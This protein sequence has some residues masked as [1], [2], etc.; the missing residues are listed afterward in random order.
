MRGRA[1]RRVF[2]IA[3]LRGDFGHYIRTNP[4][5]AEATRLAAR[6][7]IRPA[8]PATFPRKGGKGRAPLREGAALP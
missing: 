3:A 5:N 4:V 1:V 8:P 7:L 2:D 6:P